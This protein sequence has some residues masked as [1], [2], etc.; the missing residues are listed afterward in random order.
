MTT[1]TAISKT[2]LRTMMTVTVTAMAIKMVLLAVIEMATQ[3]SQQ[4]Q[5]LQ[6]PAMRCLQQQDPTPLPDL[7]H[8]RRRRHG[9]HGHGHGLLLPEH[10]RGACPQIVIHRIL[11][12]AGIDAPVARRAAVVTAAAAVAVAAAGGKGAEG[13]HVGRDMADTT[14]TALLLLEVGGGRQESG[15][16]GK[17]RSSEASTWNTRC[18]DTR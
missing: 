5:S 8:G 12:E 16:G 3:L 11:W 17:N 6:R 4:R 9:G 10:T 18:W 2:T 13:I 7:R 15:K 1:G 14:D